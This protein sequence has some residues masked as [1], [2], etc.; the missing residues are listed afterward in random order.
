MADNDISRN[1]A[2]NIEVSVDSQSLAE[3]RDIKS[4]TQVSTQQ[5]Q[6]QKQ[7]SGTHNNSG[8]MDADA[9]IAAFENLYN[10]SS[11]EISAIY[12]LCSSTPYLSATSG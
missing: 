5:T 8:L 4:S 6:S 3:L 9:A 7:T 12:N 11:N 2:L 10:N 1:Y